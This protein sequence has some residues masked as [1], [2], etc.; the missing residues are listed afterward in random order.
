MIIHIS[1]AFIYKA[2]VPNI[3]IVM[4]HDTRLE[5]V[6]Q[7]RWQSMLNGPVERLVVV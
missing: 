4:L 3:A 5:S 1:E 2:M 7:Q 6:Q